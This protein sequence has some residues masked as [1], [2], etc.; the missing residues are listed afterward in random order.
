MRFFNYPRDTPAPRAIPTSLFSAAVPIRGAFAGLSPR[1]LLSKKAGVQLR[2]D[3][4]ALLEQ[5]AM[6]ERVTWLTDLTKQLGFILATN[7]IDPSA[8]SEAWDPTGSGSITRNEFR[9][10]LRGLVQRHGDA[11]HADHST[12][13]SAIDELFD[14]QDD[15]GSGVIDVSEVRKLLYRLKVA[16]SDR[17]YCAERMEELARAERLREVARAAIEARAQLDRSVALQ[18]A[19]DASQQQLGADLQV[20]LGLACNRRRVKAA[21]FVGQYAS[22]EGGMSA[23]DFCSMATALLPGAL[24]ASIS[25]VNGALSR[26][27][28]ETLDADGS[29]ALDM[30]EAAAALAAM[31]RRAVKM[32]QEH[33]ARSNLAR[34]S[35]RKAAGAVGAA[36]EAWRAEQRTSS[37]RVASALSAPSSPG[38]P[39]SPVHVLALVTGSAKGRIPMADDDEGERAR[40]RRTKQTVEQAMRRLRTQSSLSM[41]WNSWTDFVEVRHGKLALAR[42]A[43]HW[44]LVRDLRAAWEVWKRQRE[45]AFRLREM[46][47]E[48][49]RNLFPRGAKREGLARAVASWRQRAVA[50]RRHWQQGMG[51]GETFQPCKALAEAL[52][53]AMLACTPHA[54]PSSS[55]TQQSL[56]TTTAATAQSGQAKRELPSSSDEAESWNDCAADLLAVD[57]DGPTLDEVRAALR[58]S[59]SRSGSPTNERAGQGR[60]PGR[61]PSRP[62]SSRPA[63]SAWL[64]RRGEER[65]AGVTNMRELP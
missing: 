56:Q 49:A 21:D 9:L 63:L 43:A 14:A 30:K 12:N 39:S 59:R 48:A 55:T 50:T 6:L 33:D 19:A 26:L 62:G 53:V 3:A 17:I 1:A 22:S 23:D 8:Q 65:S 34:A 20:Q 35:R 31:Q 16:G 2:V 45:S 44:L 52:R 58:S 32:S 11:E 5:A 25:D 54:Q 10:R 4:D 28:A 60:S 37:L 46:M 41:G 13:A 27:F 57:A 18:A 40:R 42:R 64:S 15:D 61:S 36:N 29:G 24:L 38:S 7:D 47:A 51:G